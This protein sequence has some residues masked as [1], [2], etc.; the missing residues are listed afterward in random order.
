MTERFGDRV[1]RLRL[2]AGLTRYAVED[3]AGLTHGHLW[4]IEEGGRKTVQADTAIRIAAVLGVT[5][6]HLV[7]GDGP[8][9]TDEQLAQAVEEARRAHRERVQRGDSAP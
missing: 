2:R 5:S 1:K 8:P 6:E 9:P 4:Q 3:L 7:I